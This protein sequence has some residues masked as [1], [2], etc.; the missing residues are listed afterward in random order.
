M[1]SNLKM[2]NSILISK[3]SVLKS[4]FAFD[5]LVFSNYKNV[6]AIVMVVYANF[7]YKFIDVR[8]KINSEVI[9]LKIF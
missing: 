6:I 9:E 4:K 2:K 1:N 7:K 8:C 5:N 3:F